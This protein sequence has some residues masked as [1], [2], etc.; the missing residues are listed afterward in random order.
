MNDNYSSHRNS[1]AN[2]PQ[3]TVSNLALQNTFCPPLT[4][5]ITTWQNVLLGIAA[6]LTVLGIGLLIALGVIV[7]RKWLAFHIT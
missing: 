5:S 2:L 4:E 7:C 1:A 6:I 3:S